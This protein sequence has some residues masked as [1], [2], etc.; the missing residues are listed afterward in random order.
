MK[1]RTQKLGKA[2]R[3]NRTSRSVAVAIAAALLL[4]AQPAFAASGGAGGFDWLSWGVSIVNL[5][6]FLGILYKFAGPGITKHFE[7]RRAQ[8]LENLDEARALREEAE[9][10]LEEYSARLDSLEAE[11][12]ALLDEYHMQGEREKKRIIEEA[13]AQVDKMRAD[14]KTSVEQEI[15]K[16]VASLER[17]MVEQAVEQAESIARAELDAGRQK[18]LLDSYTKELSSMDALQGSGRAA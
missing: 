14:A 15:K 1:L 12:K 10:R 3:T 4:L 9:A 11:R 6:I 17:Q 16:A 2:R 5:L 18:A 7:G 8:L 13:K